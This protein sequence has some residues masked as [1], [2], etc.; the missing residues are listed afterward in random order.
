MIT[1]E[2]FD[3]KGAAWK[4]VFMLDALEKGIVVEPFRPNEEVITEDVDVEIMERD[5]SCSE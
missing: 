4:A 1:R 5:S 3:N 2:E